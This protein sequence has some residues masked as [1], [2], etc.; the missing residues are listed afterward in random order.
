MAET[1]ALGK[2]C[3]D[4]ELNIETFLQDMNKGRSGNKAAAQRARKISLDIEKSLK[5]YRKLSVQAQ[6]PLL[7]A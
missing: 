1:E 2:V 6:G 7:P 3:L 5:S 4:L